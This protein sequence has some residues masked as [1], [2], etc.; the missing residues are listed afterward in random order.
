MIIMSN[1][2]ITFLS[3]FQYKLQ[4]S[5]FAEKQPLN[6]NQKGKRDFNLNYVF[7]EILVQIQNVYATS[8]YV[9]LSVAFPNWCHCPRLF[10]SLCVEFRGL[11]H[12]TLH[13]CTNVKQQMFRKMDNQI[14]W[15]NCD[16]PRQKPVS[17]KFFI[18]WYSDF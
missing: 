3:S 13:Q 6:T 7:V 14:D 10:V 17:Q 11:K 5:E 18:I 15:L 4:K 16:P 8:D 1:K 12:K 2:S 9:A